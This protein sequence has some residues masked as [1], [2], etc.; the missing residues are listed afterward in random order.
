MADNVRC[1]SGYG[2]VNEGKERR[3][4]LVNIGSLIAE[5]YEVCNILGEGTFG[6]VC[7]CFDHFTME[8]VAIKIVVTDTTGNNIYSLREVV[9]L[10]TL[11]QNASWS[12]ETPDDRIV[13]IPVTSY[14]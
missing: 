6:R 13:V 12:H 2:G 3:D 5:R 7:K 10:E 1:H 8:F 4:S 11:C 14:D 9:I